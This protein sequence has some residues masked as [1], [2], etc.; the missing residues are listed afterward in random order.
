MR[1]EL[2]EK[3]VEFLDLT[4]GEAEFLESL[5]EAKAL[6]LIGSVDPPA[7]HL[8]PNPRQQ[9]QF[10]VIANRAGGEATLLTDLA[11]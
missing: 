3:G 9:P 2:R 5:D 8:A 4:Q 11:N 7:R 1:T 10:L 6:E